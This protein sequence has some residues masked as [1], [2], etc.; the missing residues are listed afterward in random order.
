MQCN[1]IS[2]NS[3]DA[4]TSLQLQAETEPGPVA[5]GH[6]SWSTVLR[7]PDDLSTTHESP[8]YPRFFAVFRPLFADRQS[9]LIANLP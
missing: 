7:T 6:S 3:P 8:R 9:S 2:N 1:I 5:V 4:R